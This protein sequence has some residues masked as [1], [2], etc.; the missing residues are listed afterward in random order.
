MKA[1]FRTVIIILAAF[2]S[3]DLSAQHQVTTVILVRHAE[4]ALDQ[5][6]DPELT[7]EGQVRAGQLDHMLKNMQ[8][9]AVYSTP[10]QRTKATVEN[11]AK[12]HNLDIREYNP[13]DLADMVRI[14]RESEGKTLLISGHSNSTPALINMI[15]EEDK[16]SS[17]DE[18]DYDNLYIVT[19]LDDHES[20]VLALQYGA[21]SGK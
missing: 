21:E 6:S 5:G 17:F 13:A 7:A 15:V 2:A 12:S 4:K 3:F 19:L 20:H 18:S 14:I 10:F 1:V 11:V 16:Y 9:D 8:I